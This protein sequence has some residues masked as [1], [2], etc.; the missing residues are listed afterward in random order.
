MKTVHLG[1]KI[2]LFSYIFEECYWG[3]AN[4]AEKFTA[5]SPPGFGVCSDYRSVASPGITSLP[6]ARTNAYYQGLNAVY[7]AGYSFSV[8]KYHFNI[9]FQIQNIVE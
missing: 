5:L 9:L 8:E 4:A 6:N 7:V 2:V 1:T 3:G